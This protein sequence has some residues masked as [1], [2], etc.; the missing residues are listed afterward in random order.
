MLE[1]LILILTTGKKTKSYSRQR[2]QYWMKG[3]SIQASRFENSKLYPKFL[4]IS[5]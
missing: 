3:F 5:V 1:C 4:K 2:Q